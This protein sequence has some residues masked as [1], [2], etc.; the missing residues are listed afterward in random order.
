MP[1]L[2]DLL[3]QFFFPDVPGAQARD[4]LVHGWELASGMT[5]DALYAQSLDDALSEE[6]PHLSAYAGAITPR[7]SRAELAKLVRVDLGDAGTHLLAMDRNSG[8]FLT[9]LARAMQAQRLIIINQHNL[10]TDEY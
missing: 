9:E 4:A 3:D 5:W 8:T 6:L 1:A 2:V 7:P 10:F